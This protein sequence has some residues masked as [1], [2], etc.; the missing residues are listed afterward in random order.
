MIG[1]YLESH[2]P[3]LS[4]EGALFYC[5]DIGIRFEIGP[6]EIGV[7]KDLNKKVFNNEYFD[8]ALDRSLLIFDFLFSP[9][10]EIVLI[11]KIFSDGR[12]KIKKRSFLTRVLSPNVYENIKFSTSRKM[13]GKSYC[14]KI[15]SIKLPKSDVNY[16]QVFDAVINQD[17]DI[18]GKNYTQGQFYFI[19]VTKKL[20]FHLYDDRGLDVVAQDRSNL[21]GIYK[22]HNDLI[23]DYER[24]KIDQ[25][26]IGV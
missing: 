16:K 24:E 3:G 10:D 22:E 21:A 23:L 6:A 17:F 9:D 8:I 11:Y 13:W 7:W 20:I 5:W 25:I 12:K 4:L 19:N 14:C 18:R 1:K 15:A 2:F 26:F